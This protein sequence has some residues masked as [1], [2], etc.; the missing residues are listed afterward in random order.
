MANSVDFG[1]LVQG[2][3]AAFSADPAKANFVFES[4]TDL[5]AGCECRNSARHHSFIIDE[6]AELGGTDRGANPVETLLAALAACR[7]ITYQYHAG[8]LGVPLKSVSIRLA[9]EID[10]RGFLA[11]DDAIR[12]GFKSIKGEAVLDTDASPAQVEALNDAVAK[13]C[14]V[15]DTV[16]NLTTISV[17]AKVAPG[18][19]VAAE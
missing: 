17:T 19:A 14:P 4:K 6:P 12:P 3:T 18:S 5:V 16:K 7:V 10:L 8:R 9:G 13:Y 1:A 11:M 2:A 15:A